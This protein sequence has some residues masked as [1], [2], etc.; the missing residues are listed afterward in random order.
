MR[1]LRFMEANL[2]SLLGDEAAYL[3]DYQAKVS[4]DILH[5]PSPDWV[6]R[7]FASSDCSPEV[8]RSL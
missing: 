2:E 5:L 8:L 4:K 6:N 3:L 7:I 1:K